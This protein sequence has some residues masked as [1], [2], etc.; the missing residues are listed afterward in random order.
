MID[1]IE[2]EQIKRFVIHVIKSEK[3][4]E[5]YKKA[6]SSSG[7]YHHPIT[8]NIDG[9][10]NHVFIA[11]LAGEQLIEQF[12][13]SRNLT[14]D[15]CDIIRAAI[16]LH[17]GWK[18]TNK[19]GE[20]G[21][22]TTKDHAYIGYQRILTYKGNLLAP[23][24][25]VAIDYIAE[26]VRFHMG[27]FSHPKEDREIAIQTKSIINSIV[28]MADILASSGALIEYIRKADIK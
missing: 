23:L 26:A 4:V 21:K 14:P 5:T 16:I 17:D 13:E 2:N 27:R 9:L 28:M 1:Y 8:N 11:V 25:H 22:H 18:Y 12:K 20:I 15:T 19:K 6:S 3:I 7:N 10:K 24:H